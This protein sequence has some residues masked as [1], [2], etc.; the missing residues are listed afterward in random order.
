MEFNITNGELCVG[1]IE[2]RIVASSSVFQI[3]DVQTI[4]LSSAFDTPPEALI[5]GTS[6]LPLAPKG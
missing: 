3:G 5:V 2:V 6:F 4:Q 1:Q